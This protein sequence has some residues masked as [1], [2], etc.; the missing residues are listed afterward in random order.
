MLIVNVGDST[1]FINT[2]EYL[3]N[4]YETNPL[5]NKQKHRIKN[6]IDGYLFYK[7]ICYIIKMTRLELPESVDYATLKRVVSKKLEAYFPGDLRQEYKGK[8]KNNFANN[9][10]LWIDAINDKKYNFTRYLDYYLD[11]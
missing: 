10:D 9:E 4:L 8:I 3:I 7:F 11:D 6:R 1:H 5:T 2:I